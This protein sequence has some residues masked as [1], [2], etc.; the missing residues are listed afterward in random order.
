MQELIDRGLW[1]EPD[2]D[3]ESELG[4]EYDRQMTSEFRKKK[5]NKFTGKEELVWVCPSGNNHARDCGKMQ[6]VAATLARLL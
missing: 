3:S 6:V 5:V 4:R 1:I 2:N